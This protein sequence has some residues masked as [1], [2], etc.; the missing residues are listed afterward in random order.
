MGF[1][2]EPNLMVLFSSLGI[3]CVCVY[4]TIAYFKKRGVGESKPRTQKTKPLNFSAARETFVKH[5]RRLA[6]QSD[7][8]ASLLVCSSWLGE[9][10][11]LLCL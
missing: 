11:K 2:V 7:S 6:G 9:A 4:I 3:V 10:A 5:S 8:L 1:V